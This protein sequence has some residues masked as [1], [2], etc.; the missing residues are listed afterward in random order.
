[1]RQFIDA[2]LLVKTETI[3][4][5]SKESLNLSSCFG[6]LHITGSFKRQLIGHYCWDDDD[7]LSVQIA[8]HI[9]SVSD[10]LEFRIEFIWSSKLHFRIKTQKQIS[11]VTAKQCLADANQLVSM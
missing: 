8:P 6:L 2:Q 4:P 3:F 9:F 10:R 11:T 5:C 7:N 1:M